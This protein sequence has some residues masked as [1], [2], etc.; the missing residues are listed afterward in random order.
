MERHGVKNSRASSTVMCSTS[1]MDLPLRRTWLVSGSK[2]P[3][4]QVSQRMRTSGR[5][6][7]SMVR[8]PWP[9]QAG[10]RPP[11]VLKEKREAV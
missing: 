11:A 10:Q 1:A 2:R 5:K 9:S 6:F 7:I 8:T 4:P 3:P